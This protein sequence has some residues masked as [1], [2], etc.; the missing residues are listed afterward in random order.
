MR[1]WAF[2]SDL[3]AGVCNVWSGRPPPLHIHHPPNQLTNQTLLHIP[4]GD[5][6]TGTMILSLLLGEDD[7][8]FSKEELDLFEEHFLPY[9]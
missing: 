5:G 6:K 2:C 7:I 3:C 9:G 8:N 1:A 4:M